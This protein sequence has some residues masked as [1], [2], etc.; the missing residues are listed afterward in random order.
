[1]EYTGTTLPYFVGIGW[2]HDEATCHMFLYQMVVFT[3]LSS[4][5]G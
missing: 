2:G 3:L 1:M 4:H 5:L